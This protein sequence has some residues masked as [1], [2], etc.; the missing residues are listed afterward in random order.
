MTR[1]F[2]PLKE[3][4][5][6]IYSLASIKKRSRVGIVPPFLAL[7]I[8]VWQRCSAAIMIVVMVLSR[9]SDSKGI[10]TTTHG[11]F[12]LLLSYLSFS[13]ILRHIQFCLIRRRRH[14]PLR[15][16]APGP[17]IRDQYPSTCPR[18]CLFILFFLT[19]LFLFEC[20]KKRCFLPLFF[21]NLPAFPALHP[22]PRVYRQIGCI[23]EI[24]RIV[25]KHRTAKIK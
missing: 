23:C 10:T 19:F 20:G 9:W 22:T 2:L 8:V 13:L 21:F 7:N 3:Q 16:P 6:Q 1:V 15:S 24:G 14:R 25:F 5:C 12:F 11:P 4:Q 18:D 17:F